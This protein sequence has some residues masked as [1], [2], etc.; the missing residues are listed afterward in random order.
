MNYFQYN[1]RI[2][3]LEKVLSERRKRNLALK[4][5]EM[6]VGTEVTVIESLLTLFKFA[7][8]FPFLIDRLSS[9]VSHGSPVK[10]CL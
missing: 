8:L 7:F 6:D 3:S 4:E 10:T 1:R 2:S 9:L 5:N